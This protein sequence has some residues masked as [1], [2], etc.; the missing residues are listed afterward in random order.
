MVNPYNENCGKNISVFTIRSLPE[1]A[2]DYVKISNYE[3]IAHFK[4]LTLND[5]DIDTFEVTSR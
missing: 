1:D 2:L 5:Y 4:I 3:L